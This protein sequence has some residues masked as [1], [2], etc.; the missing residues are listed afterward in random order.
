[1]MRDVPGGDLDSCLLRGFRL[2]MSR[3][4][5][6]K[7]I[8]ILRDYAKAQLADLKRDAAAANALLG[9][10]LKKRGEPAL[11]ASLVLGA[12]LLLNTDNFITRE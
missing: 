5:S 9:D 10:A 12:R 2:C 11:C 3:E 1:M 6:A 7:E 8:A 4:P